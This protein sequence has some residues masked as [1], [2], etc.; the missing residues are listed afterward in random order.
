MVGLLGFLGFSYS[1]RLLGLANSFSTQY[2]LDDAWLSVIRDALGKPDPV[3]E[4]T[5][6][7]TA[8]VNA[9]TMI[10][11]DLVSLYQVCRPPSETMARRRMC[12][13]F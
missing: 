6:L 13:N 9:A 3:S 8:P 10:N 7:Q 4:E 2:L 1:S 5:F 12:G 11:Q